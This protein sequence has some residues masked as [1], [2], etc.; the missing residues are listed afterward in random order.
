MPGLGWPPS[1]ES[2]A[3]PSQRFRLVLPKGK[4]THREV[5]ELAQGHTARG[6]AELTDVCTF[7]PEL[8]QEAFCGLGRGQGRRCGEMLLIWTA[9]L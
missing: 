9:L 3:R 2:L 1:P 8:G 7:S 5:K 4:W 6:Q